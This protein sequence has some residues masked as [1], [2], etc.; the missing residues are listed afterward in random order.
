MDCPA[1]NEVAARVLA[2]FVAQRNIAA[3]VHKST[4]ALKTA[5]Q[6]M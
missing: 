1:V 4:T 3:A 5:W 6:A 2:H